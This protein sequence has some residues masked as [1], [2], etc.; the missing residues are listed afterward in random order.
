MSFVILSL[1]CIY[2]FT[3]FYKEGIFLLLPFFIQYKY[4]LVDYLFNV[5]CFYPLLSLLL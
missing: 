1:L 5:M 4:G 2:S 3:F